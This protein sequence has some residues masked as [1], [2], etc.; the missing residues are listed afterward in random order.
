MPPLTFNDMA[1]FTKASLGTFKIVCT[2]LYSVNSEVSD[3][4]ENVILKLFVC[5]LF[6]IYV[7]LCV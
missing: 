7:Q 2:G 5:L 1:Y 3:I 6:I 4:V